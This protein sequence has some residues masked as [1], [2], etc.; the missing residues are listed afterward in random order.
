MQSHNVEDFAVTVRL[1]ESILF[2][3]IRRG[4]QHRVFTEFQDG[5]RGLLCTIYQIYSALGL[6]R[7]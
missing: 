1:W 6:N 5:D 2:P 7:T 3:G 4:E